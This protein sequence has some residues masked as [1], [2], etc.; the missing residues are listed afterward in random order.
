MLRRKTVRPVRFPTDPGRTGNRI[1]P[2]GLRLDRRRWVGSIAAPPGRQAVRPSPDGGCQSGHVCRTGRR[3]RVCAGR[4][5]RDQGTVWAR[6]QRGLGLAQSVC[7]RRLAGRRKQ[8][9]SK[10]VRNVSLPNMKLA[11][12]FDL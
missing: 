7:F 8:P 10:E 4:I 6:R 5:S 3:P 2:V 9:Q 1:L 11:Y 12:S